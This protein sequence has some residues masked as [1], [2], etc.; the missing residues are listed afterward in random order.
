MAHQ[1]NAILADT[2][3]E[4]W[5]RVSWQRIKTKRILTARSGKRVQVAFRGGHL[6]PAYFFQRTLP[7]GA[8]DSAEFSGEDEVGALR[9]NKR[10]D[11]H[12]KL[13]NRGSRS[14]KSS[15]EPTLNTRNDRGSEISVEYSFVRRREQPAR[16][17][18]ENSSGAVRPR[19]TSR[20]R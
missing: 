2:S 7:L 16:Y 1:V 20:F 4:S 11:P 9:P 6:C 13:A 12:S 15:P 10:V 8:Q 3:T 5:G 18:A 19:S 17:T 14:R